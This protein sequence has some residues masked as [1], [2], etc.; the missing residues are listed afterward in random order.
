MKKTLLTTLFCIGLLVLANAQA[1]T[2]TYTMS[3]KLADDAGARAAS[4][5]WHPV[6]NCDT[7]CDCL[8]ESAMFLNRLT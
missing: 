6:L 3:L 7:Y 1:K 8:T 2:L 5:A 4:I